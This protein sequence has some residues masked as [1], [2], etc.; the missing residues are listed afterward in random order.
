[1]RGPT[2]GLFLVGEPLPPPELDCRTPG[3]FEHAS[4]A[5]VPRVGDA[6]GTRAASAQ[7]LSGPRDADTGR[8]HLPCEGHWLAVGGSRSHSAG[9]CCTGSAY[10]MSPTAY[11]HVAP[12]EYE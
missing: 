7:F 12:C 6:A 2:I 8:A 9:S 11:R 4:R 1:M 3:S 5:D 10:H